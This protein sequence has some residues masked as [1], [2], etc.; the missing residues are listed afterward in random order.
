METLEATPA[1]DE[2]APSPTIPEVGEAMAQPF[3]EAQVQ[4]SLINAAVAQ[5]SEKQKGNRFS[6]AIETVKNQ[7]LVE[8][9]GLGVDAGL[10]ALGGIGISAM[11]DVAA[12][13]M[14]ASAADAGLL[15][16]LSHG[17]AEHSE[18]TVQSEKVPRGKLKTLG[19]V[20]I[21]MA[22]AIAAQ[23]VG[24]GVF[25]HMSSNASHGLEHYMVMLGSK[26][27]ATTGLNSFF[28]R[29]ARLA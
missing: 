13:E 5:S 29:K 20:G 23:K 15:N 18:Q 19:K 4:L 27:G 12:R 6:G 17:K 22:A 1:L 9:V 11:K 14:V 28:K 24:P 10:I 26:V 7:G 21:T 16:R 3:T 25:E 8:V 2:F